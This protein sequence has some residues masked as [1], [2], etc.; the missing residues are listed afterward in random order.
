MKN[1]NIGT[2]NNNAD[3]HYSK[4]KA[5][6]KAKNLNDFVEINYVSLKGKLIT[7]RFHTC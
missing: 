6:H 1:M 4:A 5:Q 2:K 3:G 7:F